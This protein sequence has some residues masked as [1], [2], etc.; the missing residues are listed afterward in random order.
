MDFEGVAFLLITGLQPE[1]EPSE[2]EAFRSR[3]RE[4]R[5]LPPDAVELIR[6]LDPE[7]HPMRLLRAGLSAVGCHELTVG[8]DLAGERQ[9]QELRM[10]GQVAALVA[11]IFRH[12]SGRPP[13]AGRK[14]TAASPR[15]CWRAL[16]RP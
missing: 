8:D 16:D 3:L 12:R 15:A 1:D 9:W 11:E 13:R 10:V 14:R 4:S 5:T 2:F 7:T 6:S